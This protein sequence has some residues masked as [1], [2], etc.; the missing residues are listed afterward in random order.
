ML[1]RMPKAHPWITILLRDN[2]VDYLEE[3]GVRFDIE[4]GF[5]IPAEPQDNSHINIRIMLH[6]V[7]ERLWDEVIH[8]GLTYLATKYHKFLISEVTARDPGKVSVSV[9]I[10]S[11]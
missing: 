3:K 5:V 10:R 1:V 11:D 8:Y 6:Q 9:E 2:I 7:N 4:G